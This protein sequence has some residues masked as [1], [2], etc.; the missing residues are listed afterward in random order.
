MEKWEQDCSL[1]PTQAF[2]GELVETSKWEARLF[3]VEKKF[4]P[5]SIILYD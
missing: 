5:S 1:P 3:R 2:L 4:S